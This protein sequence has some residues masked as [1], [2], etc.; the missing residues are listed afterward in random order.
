MVHGALHIEGLGPAGVKLHLY[1]SPKTPPAPNFSLGTAAGLFGFGKFV[2]TKAVKRNGKYS[3]TRKRPK[4]RK[5]TYFQMRFED[6]LLR[7]QSGESCEG[8]S[9]SGQTIPCNGE[10]IAPL[11]SSM[12]RV[13]PRKR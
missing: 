4:G 12:I 3:I 13:A 11:T 2:R 7:L 8:P 5:R 6:Y 1:S 9:P 10:T